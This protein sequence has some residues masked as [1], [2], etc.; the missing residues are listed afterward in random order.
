L[1]DVKRGEYAAAAAAFL[2]ALKADGADVEVANNLGF[3]F[4]MAGGLPAARHAL[5]YTLGLAPD[6]GATWNTLG[7]VLAQENDVDGAVGCFRNLL[8]FSKNP[9]SSRTYLRGRM[10]D[11]STVPAL[12]TAIEQVL[13]ESPQADEG[14]YYVVARS[15]K[16][17]APYSQE[18]AIR[19]AGALQGKGYGASVWR[20]VSGYYAVVIGEAGGSDHANDLRQ[21]KVTAGDADPDAFL[22]TGEK[23]VQRVW[24]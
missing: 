12:R 24:P 4:Q 15:L 19:D 13:A 20:S 22:A 6:R 16:I 1:D 14:T 2:A 11:P 10:D 9:A 3:A 7:F 18:R 17:E 5:I 23:L 8:L 21:K